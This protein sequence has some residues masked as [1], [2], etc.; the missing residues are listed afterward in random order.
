[1]S[2]RARLLFVDDEER[3]ITLMKV[4]FRAKYEVYGATSGQ[5]A[6][7]ILHKTPIHVLVC[8]QRMP[9]MAGIELLSKARGLSP[10]TMR[11]LLTGYSDLAAIVG[12]VNDGEVYRF[13]NKPWNNEVL[14]TVV[15]EAAEI[16]LATGVSAANA[17]VKLKADAMVAQVRTELLVLDDDENSQHW[18]GQLLGA[19]WFSLPFFN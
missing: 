12:S 1:M 10:Q 18:I 17:S 11:I 19:G 4:I 15:G 14:R 7:E 2:D 9:G 5:Q 3:I 16:A 6:L 8:D 13:I